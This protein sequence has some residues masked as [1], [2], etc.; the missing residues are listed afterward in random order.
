MAQRISLVEENAQYQQDAKHAEEQTLSLDDESLLNGTDPRIKKIK[1]LTDL[2]I[3][4]LLGL[5]YM[6][7]AIDRVNLGV[8]LFLR[9]TRQ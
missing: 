8:R 9:P 6:M 1:R 3:C 2:R 4:A 7:A 5:L